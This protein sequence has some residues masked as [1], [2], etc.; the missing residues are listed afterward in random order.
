MIKNIRVTLRI[1]LTGLLVFML[2]AGHHVR[3]QQQQQAFSEDR[4]LFITQLNDYFQ[5]QNN[6]DIQNSLK[7][8]VTDWQEGKFTNEVEA[9]II[10]SSEL[11]RKA[12]IRPH[13]GYADYLQ[14]L[15]SFTETTG[16]QS[17]LAWHKA[18]QQFIDLKKL[19]QLKDF[20]NSTTQ[21]NLHH[22]LFKANANS[23]KFNGSG[24][25]YKY[26]TTL[27]VDLKDIDLVSYS[28]R[29]S[30]SITRTSGTYYPLYNKFTGNDGKVSWDKYGY[31]SNMVY[32][33]LGYY[34][35]NLKETAYKAD[36]VNFYHKDYFNQ[37]LIGSLEDRVLAGVPIDKSTFPRFVSNSHDLGIKNLYPDI[38]YYG[39]FSIEGSKIIGSGDSYA[40]ASIFIKKGTNLLMKLSSKSFVIRPDRFVSQRAAAIIYYENDSLFHPGLQVRY[41]ADIQELSLLRNGEGVSGSPFF[42]SFH[43][44]DMYFQGLYYTINNDS[45][46]FEM[47][48]GLNRKETAVFESTNF[49]SEE[50][51]EKLQGIDLINPLNV[52]FSYTEKIKRN[53]FLLPELVEY[54]RKPYEQVKAQV[55][56]LA[57]GGFLSYYID[58]DRIEV[59]QRL[60]DYIK[61]K[62]KKT[63]YDVI[64]IRSN[65]EKGANAVLNLKTFNLTVKGVDSVSLSIRQA[66]NIIPRNKEIIIGKNR[67]FVFT[68]TVNAGYF[69][70]YANKSSF[71]YD[72]FKLDMPTIDSMGFEVDTLNK[73]TQK[74]VRIPV[75]NVI[76][77]LSGELLID[78]PG[79]KSGIKNFPVFP[80]FNSQNDAYVYYD[81]HSIKKGA[82]KREDF[83]YT[84]F[85]FTIDSL[86]S[87]TTEGLS[88]DGSLFSG[89]IMPVI[90]EP[91]RVMEDYSLG[92]HQKLPSRGISVYDS[93][94]TYYSDITLNN[95]GFHG[96]GKLNFMTSESE[97]PDFTF[98][99]DSLV[100]DLTSFSIKEKHGSPSFPE[101]TGEGV[102]QFWVPEKDSMSLQTLPGKEFVM[103]KSKS[104][105]S[106]NL[107]LTSRGLYGSGKSRLDN[108][109]IL[110]N[111]FSFKD[112]SFN[113]DT[114]NFLLYYPER[115]TLSL[116]AQMN[117][118]Y[119]DFQ[120]RSGEFGVQGESQRIEL[121]H[122]KYV[123]YMDKLEWSMEESELRLTNSLVQRSELADT[124]NLKELVDYDFTG[125]EFIST[126]PV[127]DSLK[128]FA[129]E[130]IYNMKDNI[131]NAR[132]V[133]IIRVADVAIFPGD[134][135][136]TILSDGDMQA[137]KGANIIADRAQK[138]H[139]IYDADVK[140]NSRKNY[141]ASGNLD[142][143]DDVGNI[144]PL[145]FNPVTVDATDKTIGYASVSPQTPLP[146][147]DHFNFIG[148]I[149]LHG[150]NKNLYFDGVYQLHNEC[151]T[152]GRPWIRFASELAAN[153]IRLPVK[154]YERDSINDP[155]LFGVVYSDF[156]SSI[157][158]SLFE[159]PKAFGDTL[160]IS[161]E[162]FI[163]YDHKS[164]SY[165]AG[166]N[167]R[168]DNKTLKGNLITFSTNQCVLNA[169]GA[170]DL[171]AAMGNVKLNAFGDVTQYT[172]V[173]S[174][175]FILSMVVDFFF[176]QQALDRLQEDLQVSELGSLDVNSPAFRSF[177]THLI[178][179]QEA[180]AFLEELNISGQVKKMP[181][182]FNKP[183]IFNNTKMIWDRKLKSFV[184]DG[185][186]GIAAIQG[187]IVNRN[188]DGYI[189]IG[190]RR[191]GDV[192]NIYL[193]LNPLVWYFFSYSNGIMQAISSNNEFNTILAS[194]KENKRTLSGKSEGDYQFIISTPE[195][196]M[197]F[198]R[199]MQQRIPDVE[200]VNP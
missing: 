21:F 165:M 109:D 11:M 152:E 189:E 191:T 144:Q 192:L 41:S 139:R 100:A 141:T 179:E 177:L 55:I 64:Q 63:D 137:L 10:K 104:Y 154:A 95:Q 57:N 94:G 173:D 35:I 97:S 187:N 53:N 143:V 75:R 69:T 79:N 90:T 147:N 163:R 54:M 32:A 81:Y 15:S 183:L 103:F 196:R 70:F 74:K 7:E 16:N 164:E 71:E 47:L 33:V 27:K 194:L 172:L 157:Y 77:N 84:V 160:L 25:N 45:L 44:L 3:A 130:A 182:A 197:A 134:G 19:K 17:I 131:I 9:E 190:K 66:V 85:P 2:I 118:G 18:L 186:I 124:T 123:C 102:H 22:I 119:V 171:G 1:S 37:P 52:I 110:S 12:G 89:K 34:S 61:A 91:L 198:M 20:L 146:L 114:T 161:T 169:V 29:D 185:K 93:Q 50:R 86:N 176:S 39:G 101:V 56:N 193:E 30:I 38:D 170:I 120:T 60:F 127:R 82:Y 31:N 156:F 122:S 126:D 4:N 178:G 167:P 199:K 76:A 8:F 48:R 140:V 13:M 168:L 128:F 121:P 145:F 158:P 155:V 46:T 14:T 51:F 96:N 83:Y 65:V 108:A 162:G 117:S 174:S 92:F 184:S 129:M 125:S 138:H 62:S 159:K 59:K 106:G 58:N 67:D 87:F 195:A 116:S 151:L 136:V 107:A 148:K 36:T 142:Y 181:D 5:S 166:S 98:Y 43:K 88:F 24:F 133:K 180:G 80:L 78:D 111:N 40:D 153:D 149:M 73:E 188:V 68:G 135:K 150:D 23:W 6:K 112:Q 26:D 113:T 175:R 115:P 42:S 200:Q 49:Y 132:E 105:H 99:P 28:G 72:K